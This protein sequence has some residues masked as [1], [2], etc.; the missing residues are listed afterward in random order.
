MGYNRTYRPLVKIS[1]LHHYFLNDGVKIFGDNLP[2]TK[3]AELLEKY[4]LADFL[5]IKPTI[6]TEKKLRNHRTRF[7]QSNTGFQLLT[8]VDASDEDLPFVAFTDELYFDFTCTLTDA[9]FENYTDILINRE[10]IIFLSNKEPSD[11]EEET[12]VTVRFSKLS[13]FDTTTINALPTPPVDDINVDMSDIS[14]SERRG[15]FALIRIHLV[16]DPGEI[17][18][19]DGA[20]KFNPSLPEVEIMLKNRATIWQYHRSSDG[21]HVL[22]SVTEKPLTK[23]GYV[24]IND[25]TKDYPNPSV[26][27]I[28]KGE[29]EKYVDTLGDPVTEDPNSTYS[30]IFI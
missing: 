23:N 5:I 26:G 20:E 18:L 1:F 11:S 30:R 7:V 6:E 8:Q 25:G 4:R 21:V 16:G 27:I 22:S 29:D 15:K 13:E 17:T 10:K 12:A 14:A 24:T 19:T 3:A 28:Y 2:A 9:Y